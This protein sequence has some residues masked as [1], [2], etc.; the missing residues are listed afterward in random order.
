MQ[1]KVD[2]PAETDVGLHET[3]GKHVRVLNLLA[4]LLLFFSREFLVVGQN[5]AG[6]APLLLLGDS[7]G[8]GK[9]KR[10]SGRRNGY[11]AQ[12]SDTRHGCGENLLLQILR[13]D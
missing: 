2:A 6:F 5:L 11:R 4:D 13:Q 9:A 10:L 8:R 1:A 7:R 12:C 3:R